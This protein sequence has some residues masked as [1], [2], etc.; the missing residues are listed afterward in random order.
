MFFDEL[1]GASNVDVNRLKQVITAPVMEW[2][3]MHSEGQLSTSK[4][5]LH[6]LYQYP[7]Q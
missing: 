7:C 5:H 3:V 6:W 2:R 4:L 1:S